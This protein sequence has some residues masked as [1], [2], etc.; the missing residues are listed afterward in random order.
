MVVQDLQETLEGPP[1]V[2]W[3][4]WLDF[5]LMFYCSLTYL[6]LIESLFGVGVDMRWDYTVTFPFT[7]PSLE[8]E[9]FHNGK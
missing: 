3:F 9:I 1:W 7:D 2:Q 6:G 8:M 5:M 4:D